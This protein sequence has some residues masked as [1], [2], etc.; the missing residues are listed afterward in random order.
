M[1]SID[2]LSPTAKFLLVLLINFFIPGLGNIVVIGRSFG[3]CVLF[4][5]CFWAW[6]GGN[7][8]ITFG[9]AVLMAVKALTE[10]YPP[11][12]VTNSRIRNAYPQ[13]SEPI[14]RTLETEENSYAS[15]NFNQKLREL[16]KR[17][18]NAEL[19][20]HKKKSREFEMQAGDRLSDEEFEWDDRDSDHL[21]AQPEVPKISAR[22][23]VAQDSREQYGSELPAGYSDYVTIPKA[24]SEKNEPLHVYAKDSTKARSDSKLKPPPLPSYSADPVQAARKPT[25]TVPEGTPKLVQPDLP[26]VSSADVQGVELSERGGLA[27]ND[28]AHV[29]IKSDSETDYKPYQTGRSSERAERELVS[30]SGASVGRT[31]IEPSFSSGSASQGLQSTSDGSA[32]FQ[33]ASSSRIDP[34]IASV[35]AVSSA[36]SLT[37]S[38]TANLV[39]PS[40]ATLLNESS[41]ASLLSHRAVSSSSGESTASVKSATDGLLKNTSS[42]NLIENSSLA[43]ASLSKSGSE[44]LVTSTTDQLLSSTG[45]PSTSLLSNVLSGAAYSDPLQTVMSAGSSIL[46]PGLSGSSLNSDTPSLM[47]GTSSSSSSAADISGQGESAFGQGF[48]G[49]SDVLNLGSNTA[50]IF[51]AFGVP[52]SSSAPETTNCSKCGALLDCKSSA[53]SACAG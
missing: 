35:N 52:I 4:L 33:P 15:S 18:F 5:F 30:V 28:S 36:I 37:E 46:G 21:E 51:A 3:N 44:Q 48:F 17:D 9:W 1:K 26:A 49:G 12:S 8:A 47:T 22:D 34:N 43:T 14:T 10:L 19:V 50:D 24:K 39:Q 45:G 31:D 11:E 53:C 29:K 40:S 13:K 32:G 38:S 27:H 7:H 20:A 23:A 16:E 2:R 42:T 25:G 6:T 41:N